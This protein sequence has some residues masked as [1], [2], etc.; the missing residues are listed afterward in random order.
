M[1]DSSALDNCSGPFELDCI[2]GIG[3]GDFLRGR[4]VAVD[5]TSGVAAG[6]D[7]EG[8]LAIDVAHGE[9]I[10]VESGEVVY[11]R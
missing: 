11:E 10:V 8:R 6:I 7:R 1:D 3:P 5:A 9:R 2:V 4:P